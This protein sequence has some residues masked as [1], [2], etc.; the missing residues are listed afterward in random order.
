MQIAITGAGYSGGEADQ[1]RRD[2]AAWRKNG[3]LA[4]HR[5]RL[6]SGFRERGIAESFGEKLYAQIQ[7][8][9]E[10]GFP[11]SHA[12]SFALLVY[13]SS[14]L[15]AHKPAAFAAALV[16]SQP[17]G[18]YSPSTILQDAQRHGVIVHPIDVT[19]SDWDLTLIPPSF[20]NGQGVPEPDWNDIR[21]GLRMVKGLAEDAGRRIEAARRKAPF[22]SVEDLRARADLD[23]RALTVLAESGALDSLTNGR[24]E[25]LWDVVAPRE[26]GLFRGLPMD[27]ERPAFEP[28]TQKEQLVFDYETTGVSVADHPMRHV[29]PA[30][31]KRLGAKARLLRTSKTAAEAK[32]KSKVVVAGLVICR[33]R[34]MTASG[35]VF[36]TL[37][38][39]WGFLNLVLWERVFSQYRHVATASGLLLVRGTIEKSSG[40]IHVICDSLEP[41]GISGPKTESG[42]P[43]AVAVHE[44]LPSMSRDF[45]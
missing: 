12:A 39:E 23:K 33:Q 8:F 18:F 14:W 6:M 25:A 22:T 35:V 15:K 11:E 9:G 17:M 41:L 40:V 45:H 21:L 27:E 1:L 24:R 19:K 38:D 16:N 10:Y 36:M 32:H 26:A 30:L 42:A 31:E 3:N 5:E 28:L 7:G 37:E 44:E 4:R 13:A 29:R 2:M 34:P 43:D 20:G